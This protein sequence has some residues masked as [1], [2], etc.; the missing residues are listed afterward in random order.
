MH[1]FMEIYPFVAVINILTSLFL[2][3]SIFSDFIKPWPKLAKLGYAVLT[4]VLLLES[5]MSLIVSPPLPY[6]EELY[7]VKHIALFIIGAALCFFIIQK[8]RHWEHDHHGDTSNLNT[9]GA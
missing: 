9:T 8:K 5:L 4:G 3:I 1:P 7:V 2:Y 6:T